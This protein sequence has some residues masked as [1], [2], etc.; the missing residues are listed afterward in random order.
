M[1]WWLS[2]LADLFFSPPTPHLE[3]L[4]KL[5]A[6]KSEWLILAPSA[7]GKQNHK[8]STFFVKLFQEFSHFPRWSDT[9]EFW[10]QCRQYLNDGWS[11]GLPGCLSCDSSFLSHAFF[12]LEG[13][14]SG[15]HAVGLLECTATRQP[16]GVSR[17]WDGMA[18]RCHAW[19]YVS[20]LA[21]H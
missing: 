5:F 21:K 2:K 16:A 20:T 15:H 4:I 9:V 14:R 7:T 6:N 18:K 11:G 10:L 13:Q 19:K 17:N 8:L 12:F 3:F 1:W